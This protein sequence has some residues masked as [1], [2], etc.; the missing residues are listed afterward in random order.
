VLR[1]SVRL[2]SLP[3]PRP[4]SSEA[5]VSGPEAGLS[6]KKTGPSGDPEAEEKLRA[7]LLERFSSGS[8][9][10]GKG[11]KGAEG[12]ASDLTQADTLVLIQAS[13]DAL[14]SLGVSS[15]SD[16]T[17]VQALGLLCL[18]PAVLAA[19]ATRLQKEGAA[20]PPRLAARAAARLA[21]SHPA[22]SAT[23]AAMVDGKQGPPAKLRLPPA[24]PASGS[25]LAGLTIP[26]VRPAV[27]NPSIPSGDNLPSG[28]NSSHP[29]GE[30]IGLSH[31]LLALGIHTPN[32]PASTLPS[33]NAGWARAVDQVA[34][35]PKP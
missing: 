14:S 17:L 8:K 9:G 20:V 35:N 31:S 29:S 15:A 32:G 1:A 33:G 6:G 30:N 34:L 7:R 25:V 2:V 10:T 12:P 21:A 16:A 5:G 22:A 4:S 13:D 27:P 18:R 24:A 26:P 28:E 11:S 3:R 23:L 19:V